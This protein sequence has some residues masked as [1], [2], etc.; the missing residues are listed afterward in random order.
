[1]RICHEKFAFKGFKNCLHASIRVRIVYAKA[2][3]RSKGSIQ[4]LEAVVRR[5]PP[6][7]QVFLKI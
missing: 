3:E 6:K 1:M 2:L 4:I 7:K 5:C